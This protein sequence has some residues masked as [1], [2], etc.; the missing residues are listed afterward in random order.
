MACKPNPV[1]EQLLAAVRE[2]VYRHLETVDGICEKRCETPVFCSEATVSL[3]ESCPVGDFAQSQFAARSL[4][5]RLQDLDEGFSETLLR[6]IDERGMT[7]AQCYKRAGI[8]RKLFSKIRSN[9]RYKPSKPTVLAFAI[10]LQLDLLQTEELL[11]KTGFA[12]SHS[13]PFDVIVEYFIVNGR[14]DLQEINDTL[15]A[16]DQCLLGTQ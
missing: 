9:P 5:E 15:F 1:S 3:T 16:F 11:K 13:A 14:F 4:Q 7:D 6:L 12:L 2:Y 8:D 10:A